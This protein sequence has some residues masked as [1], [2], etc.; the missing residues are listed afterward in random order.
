[1]PQFCLPPRLFARCLAR[2]LAA[3]ALLL[4]TAST[5]SACTLTDPTP[6]I[7]GATL[8]VS[9]QE[10]TLRPGEAARLVVELRDAPPQGRYD[11]SVSGAWQGLQ[12]TPSQLWLAGTDRAVLRVAAPRTV[13]ASSQALYVRVSDGQG[14]GL[15]RVVEVQVRPARV[16]PAPVRPVPIGV[17]LLP[18]PG[19]PTQP[20]PVTPVPLLP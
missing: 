17:P 3:A 7:P 16:Q 12:V 14:R 15:L 11:L 4:G 10:L 19:A 18:E 6:P 1:M 20:A 13:A 8:R 5:L 2:S 9:P